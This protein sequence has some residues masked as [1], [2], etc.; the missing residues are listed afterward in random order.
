MNAVMKRT[1]LTATFVL[2]LAATVAAAPQRGGGNFRGGGHMNGA[3]RA[4]FDPGPRAHTAVV[5]H[6][7]VN[8]GPH[9]IVGG[10]LFYDPFWGY[11]YYAWGYPYYYGYPYAGYPYGAAAAGSVKTEVTP[12]Q[13]EVYVDGYYAGVADDY[14]GAFKRLH[15]SP[16]GHVVT[17]HLEGYRTVTQNIYVR[18]DA[19][20]KVTETME[21]VAPGEVSAPV[22]QPP[23]G[24]EPRQ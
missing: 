13:T 1:V 8:H 23:A 19:T 5:P 18:P 15:V 7:H 17:M 12:K 14:D 24:A 11:P 6:V 4:H 10:G 21:P 16:G 9:V 22:P 20:F 3:P 2:A